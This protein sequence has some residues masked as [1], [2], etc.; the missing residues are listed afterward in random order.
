LAINHRIT[1]LLNEWS[2]FTAE[3]EAERHRLMNPPGVSDLK[4]ELIELNRQMAELKSQ[5]H[6]LK[7]KIT[8]ASQADP[9]NKATF[10]VEWAEKKKNLKETLE[11]HLMAELSS[12]KS[13]PTI[14][15]EYELR[16]PVWL[17]QV[18][19]R[20]HNHQ[21]TAAAK[22][23]NAIWYWSHFTGTHK[24]A[25]AKGDTG[26]WAFVKMQG[27][28]DTDLED[29]E[30]IWDFNTGE[31]LDGSLEVFNSD[32]PSGRKKRQHTLASVLEGSYD[33]PYRESPNPYYS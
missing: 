28:L 26:K 21:K 33:G 23:V 4:G 6:L 17:Y 14:M 8:M 7:A 1:E 18:K 12:G 25:L 29:K 19:E 32:T 27:A 9:Y 5:Q 3:R 24:Y 22:I 31:F 2:G 30:A 10:D 20:L 15:N 13:V 11:Q 16:N